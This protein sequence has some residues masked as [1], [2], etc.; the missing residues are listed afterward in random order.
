[1]LPEFRL[2]QYFSQWEFRARY[3][4]AASD[5]ETMSI[6]ELLDLGSVEDRQRFLDLRLGYIETE[7]TP[8]L[9]DAVAAWYGKGLAADQV[10]AFVGAEEGMFCAM[11]ALLQPG[12]HAIVT[13]PN[14]QST[15]EIPLSICDVTGVA[16]RETAR[17]T[18]DPDEIEA[19]IRPNT[20]LL[21]INFP[22]NPTGKVIAPEVFEAIVDVAARYGLYLLSDEVYRGLERNAASTLPPA[23]LRYQRGLSLGVMSKSFGLPGLRVGWMATRD[24][25]AL[26]R[27][28]RVKHYL[29]IAGAGPS[30]FLAAL[31]LSRADRILDRLRRLIDRNL[32]LVRE[33]FGEF[34]DL[35]EWDEPEGG[36]VAFP[37]YLGGDGVEEFCRSAVEEAGVI[38]LP[39]GL[40]QSRLLPVARDRFRIGFGRENC[41]EALEVLREH[42]VRT[43]RLAGSP[44][45]AA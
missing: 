5:A 22:H 11:H 41:G 31:A 44:S 14:Y 29:S 10:L 27:M 39:S 30:E 13:V 6:A 3:N 8:G 32:E 25:E 1:M 38:L 7:G 24:R 36:C 33:F 17:W 34:P 35:F 21:A 40:F 23:A 45:G 37:R 15:E 12:D 18:V 4:L 19:A 26:A 43:G 20:R 28:A 9:R 2:E 42:L 16:L